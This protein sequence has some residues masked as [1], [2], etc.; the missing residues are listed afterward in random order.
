MT[1]NHPTL[2]VDPYYDGVPAYMTE[3]YDWAYVD[4]KWV[5]ALDHNIVVRVLLFLNDQRLMRAYLNEIVPGMKV[6][7]EVPTP[8][9][10]TS[11]MTDSK[12]P[13]S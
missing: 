3:V 12:A 7:G 10:S 6:W 8:S 5:R 13:M 4:P 9:G 11:S 2:A 1:N